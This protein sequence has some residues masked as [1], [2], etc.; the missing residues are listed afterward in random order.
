MQSV[1]GM[2]TNNLASLVL[3]PTEQLYS[4]SKREGTGLLLHKKGQKL[5]KRHG[6]AC[7]VGESDHELLLD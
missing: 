2:F 1:L 5:D 3:L 6:K 7:E 4:L